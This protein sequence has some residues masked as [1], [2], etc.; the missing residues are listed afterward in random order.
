MIVRG[1][2][3][4]DT[5]AAVVLRALGD[6]LRRNPMAWSPQLGRLC[7][8]LHEVADGRRPVD[9]DLGSWLT[10]HQVAMVEQLS[11]R[12]VRHRCEKGH[13]D[14]RKELNRWRIRP[15]AH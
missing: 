4:D 3:V 13:Y 2:V 11:E 6:Y 10:V 12:T 8:E 14:A 7:V 9:I 5:E 15:T 1:V